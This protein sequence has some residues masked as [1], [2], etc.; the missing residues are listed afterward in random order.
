MPL[1]AKEK[2]VLVWAE[3]EQN[4]EKGLITEYSCDKKEVEKERRWGL[5]R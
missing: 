5:I 4:L 1:P 2:T 3:V